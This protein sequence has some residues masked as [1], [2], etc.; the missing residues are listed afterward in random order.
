MQLPDDAQESAARTAQNQIAT[1]SAQA[2]APRADAATD[3]ANQDQLTAKNRFTT[4]LLAVRSCLPRVSPAWLFNSLLQVLTLISA[5]YLAYD[6]F[7]ETGALIQSPASDPKNPFLFPFSITNMS[8]IF[9]LRNIKWRC[10]FPFRT[11]DRILP[12]NGSPANIYDN[13]GIIASSGVKNE[14]SPGDVLNIPCG[15]PLGNMELFPFE[16]IKVLIYVDYDTNIPWLWPIH[17]SPHEQFTWIG[18]AETPQW[19]R[20]QLPERP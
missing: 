6:W 20:G 3:T 11:Y 9:T 7:Y 16:D 1:N 12:W 4:A 19:I 17:R 14:L 5:L 18:T 8:H 15:H 10:Q 13:I 2:L